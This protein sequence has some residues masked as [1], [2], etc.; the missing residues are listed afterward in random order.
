MPSGAGFADRQAR[1]IDAMCADIQAQSPLATGRSIE[2]IFIGGGTPSLFPP[3]EIA[4][5]L[6]TL[7]TAF[8]VSPDAEITM[9]ANPGSLDRRHFEGYRLA[10]VTRL[11][12]GGQSLSAAALKR[13]GRLHTPTDTIEAVENA[14]EAGFDRLNVDLMYA[15]PDQTVDEALADVRAVVELGVRHIS[16]YQLTLEPNTRFYA[17]PPRLPDDDIAAEMMQVTAAMLKDEGL[18]RYEVSALAADGHQCQ[19]N[20]NYWQFGDYLAFGAGAHGKL[21]LQAEIHRYVRP[22]HPAMYEKTG[23]AGWQPDAASRVTDAALPFEFMLNALRLTAGFSPEL[24][25]RRTGLP[26]D[27][28]ASPLQQAVDQGLLS[29]HNNVWRP[30]TLGAQFLNNLVSLFLP[31]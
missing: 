1:Y 3:D 23:G 11:S 31:D 12:I 4:R 24:F 26:I 28:V 15:L 14:T 25:E 18:D 19:H 2:T 29:L 27:V 20:L 22:M 5:L 9:E 30:T 7:G 13:L 8:A 16:H 17:D 6:M 21:S 10:G